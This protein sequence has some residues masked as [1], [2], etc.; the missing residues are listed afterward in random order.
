MAK[1]AA[2][3]SEATNELPF[4]PKGPNRSLFNRSE[5][6]RGIPSAI[7]LAI[8]RAAPRTENPVFE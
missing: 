5:Y 1:C 6:G 3:S 8:A 7:E 2:L 4:I